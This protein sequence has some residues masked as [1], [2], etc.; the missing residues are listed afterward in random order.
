MA[1]RR[2][3]HFDDA[4]LVELDFARERRD[5]RIVG[6]LRPT[7]AQLGARQPMIGFRLGDGGV[8]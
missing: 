7:S 3:A 8:H 1:S 6:Q 5:Q 2:R 4:L